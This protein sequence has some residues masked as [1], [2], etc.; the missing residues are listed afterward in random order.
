MAMIERKHEDIK[1]DCMDCPVYAI[2]DQKIIDGEYAEGHWYIAEG[3]WFTR[4]EAEAFLEQT[5]YNFTA[6][7]HVWAY[8]ARGRLKT[9]LKAHTTESAEGEDDN[10]EKQS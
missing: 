9:L 10:G 5:H 3:L 6:K 4:K 2:R 1:P 8:P 7:G